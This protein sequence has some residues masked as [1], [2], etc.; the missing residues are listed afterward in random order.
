MWCVWWG[1]YKLRENNRP[2]D[3]GQHCGGET[4]RKG[5]TKARKGPSGQEIDKNHTVWWKTLIHVNTKKVPSPRNCFVDVIG[6]FCSEITCRVSGHHVTTSLCGVY[7][8]TAHPGSE[9]HEDGFCQFGTRKR[10]MIT[11][12]N[13]I[14]FIF[15]KCRQHSMLM[16]QSN[17]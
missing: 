4:N 6:L 11:K 13:W 1:V 3:T 8:K 9:H 2:A 10:A 14:F 7:L 12:N 15:D 5:P 17:L 16:V